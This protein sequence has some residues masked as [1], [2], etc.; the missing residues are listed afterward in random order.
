MS[1]L[2]IKDVRI[3]EG[4]P[5]V[6]IPLV[7]QTEDE[8]TQEAKIVKSLK[9]DMVEWR[10]DFYEGVHHLES[11]SAMITKL[12]SIFDDILILFTFRSFKE[13]GN[14]EIDSSYYKKLIEHAIESKEIDLVDIELFMEEEIILHLISAAKENGVFSIMSNHDFVKTPSKEE[15]IKRL[16]KMQEYGAHI[17]KM[18][19]MP[20]SAGD[21]LTLMD[22]TYTMKKEYADRPII[23]M[24]M[25]GTGVVSRLAGEA[26]GSACTFASGREASAPGQIPVEELRSVLE[27]LHNRMQQ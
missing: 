16:C 11:V 10:V 14:K 12:R 23:T 6:I 19:V 4:V 21:V 25:G 3:G 1:T 13:G 15:I 18:A 27:V 2:I 22:A 26:F 20:A 5:K 7:G 24:S 17:L 8:I 9:P